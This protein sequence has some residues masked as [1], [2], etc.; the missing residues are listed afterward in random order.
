[1]I[2]LLEGPWRELRFAVGSLLRAPLAAGIMLAILTAGIGLNTAVYSVLYGILLR[3]Y[4]SMWRGF[5]ERSPMPVLIHPSAP[6]STT[7]SYN[8]L[9]SERS[10][11]GGGSVLARASCTICEGGTC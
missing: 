10:G 5:V 7:A 8:D 9:P 1:M 11:A 4:P 3:P 6:A 2:N